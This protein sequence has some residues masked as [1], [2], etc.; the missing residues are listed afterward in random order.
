MNYNQNKTNIADLRISYTKAKLN[1]EETDSCP[2]KQFEKWLD[3]A[4]E[5]K[6]IEATA[7]SLATVNESGTTFS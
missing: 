3:E 7:M 4:I 1:I 2:I 6:T 5:A